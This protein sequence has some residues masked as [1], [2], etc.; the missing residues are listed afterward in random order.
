MHLTPKCFFSLGKSLHLFE[1]HCTFLPLLNSNLDFLQAVNQKS[2]HRLLHDRAR[3]GYMMYESIPG[4]TSQISLHACLRR[5]TN[6]ANQSVTS[7]QE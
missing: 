7:N 6:D 3:K 4:L 1:M 5:L 2:G